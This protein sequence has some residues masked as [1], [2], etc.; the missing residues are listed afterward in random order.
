MRVYIIRCNRQDELTACKADT[1]LIYYPQALIR[2]S[3]IS[4]EKEEI[5]QACRGESS[6]KSK[7]HSLDTHTENDAEKIAK[8]KGYHEIGKEGHTH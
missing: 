2:M 3:K 5:E 1:N 7:P 8:R 4:D 6:R